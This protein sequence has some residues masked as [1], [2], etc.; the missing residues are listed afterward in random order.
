MLYA[1]SLKQR[2][3]RNCL[4]ACRTEQATET[5]RCKNVI[6]RYLHRPVTI[7]KPG[8]ERVQALDDI[9]RS[10]YVVIAT[11]PVH[12]LQIHPIVHKLHLGSCSSVSMQPW[13]DRHTRRHA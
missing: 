11:K 4:Q 7:T 5:K 9:S 3:N 10:G 1:F 2:F 12:R 6:D 13:A 8:I